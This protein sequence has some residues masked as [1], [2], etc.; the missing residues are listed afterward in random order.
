MKIIF[1]FLCLSFSLVVSA[2]FSIPEYHIIRDSL[3]HITVFHSGNSEKLKLSSKQYIDTIRLISSD[4][5]IRNGIVDHKGLT[6]EMY[7]REYYV[8]SVMIGYLEYKG[9]DMQRE[10][11]FNSNGNV[12]LEKHYDKGSLI[13]M[14]DSIRSFFLDPV[15]AR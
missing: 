3:T 6:G 12:F 5:R 9:P 2:Q 10:V 14:N 15:Q 8:D 11:Y 7:V 13:Y 1:S 4:I